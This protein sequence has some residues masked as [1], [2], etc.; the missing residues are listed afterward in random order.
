MGLNIRTFKDL[1][2]HLRDELREIYPRGEIDAIATIVMDY[3]EPGDARTPG[4]LRNQRIIQTGKAHSIEEI[5]R[6]LKNGKPV[7]Y[8]T[9]ETVFLDCIIKVS[10]ATLIPRQ[11]T[12]ELAA[13]IIRENKGFSGNIIDLCTGSGCIAVALAKKLP[14]ARVIA[15]D[16]S[17]DALVVASENAGRNGV[18]VTFCR[19]DILHQDHDDLPPAGIVVS[20]PP[21]VR[22]SEK[23]HMH[24]NVLDFEP[25]NA[26]FVPDDDPLVFYRA[27]LTFTSTGLERGGRLYLEINEAYGSE[28]MSLLIRSGFGDVNLVKDLNGRD[29][30]IKAV[31][32]D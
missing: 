28:M 24:R 11:E 21:Y 31:K 1:R 3:L 9:G 25:H 7:Q 32:D 4:L 27:I 12:E 19:S 29:R 14:S 22:K 13:M 10:P 17:E 8:I 30:F 5:T 20:N 18:S 16:I 15:T 26:L 2:D 23:K 6:E